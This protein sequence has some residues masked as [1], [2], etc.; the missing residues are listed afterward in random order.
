MWGGGT[1]WRQQSRDPGWQRVSSWGSG[2]DISP[3]SAI[4]QLS[5]LSKVMKLACFL[6][7]HLTLH[8]GATVRTQRDLKA[9]SVLVLIE[10]RTSDSVFMRKGRRKGL[11]RDWRMKVGVVFGT[12]IKGTLEGVGLGAGGQPTSLL[13]S[14]VCQRPCDLRLG[15]VC[16][17]YRYK[18]IKLLV[19]VYWWL[20]VTLRMSLFL[21][22]LFLLP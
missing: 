1:W 22:V 11:E 9:H 16:F 17:Q 13:I 8:L 10:G 20:L 4:C 15:C 6:V 3:G 12:R 19:N 7:S 2:L 14:P 18:F 21:C 5:C